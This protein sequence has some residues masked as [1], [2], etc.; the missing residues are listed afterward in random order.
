MQVLKE[1]NVEWCAIDHLGDT[2]F[3]EYDVIFLDTFLD[4]NLLLDV[5]AA[6]NVMLL[7]YLNKEQISSGILADTLG[8]GRVAVATKF[9]YAVE[10]LDPENQSKEGMILDERSRGILV[11]PGKPSVDQIAQALDCLVFNKEERLAMEKRAQ[12]RGHQMRWDNTAWEL[13]QHIEFIA[14]QRERVTG[15]G[16]TFKREKPSPLA[17]KNRSL[18]ISQ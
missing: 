16:L 15:R 10:L 17:E 4:E 3:R 6:T 9:M 5:Y 1:S 12:E 13:L 8:A 2:P 14:E 18:A 11:D 7:P